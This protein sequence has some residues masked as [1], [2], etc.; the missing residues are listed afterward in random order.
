M[1]WLPNGFAF[2]HVKLNVGRLR[3]C[4][5]FA[6]RSIITFEILISLKHL[7]YRSPYWEHAPAWRVIKP[8]QIPEQPDINWP[9][10]VMCWELPK[11]VVLR[12]IGR[13]VGGVTNPYRKQTVCYR[14]LKRKKE[15]LLRWS[16][17]EAWDRRGCRTCESMD[18]CEHKFGWK[19]WIKET[20]SSLNIGGLIALKCIEKLISCC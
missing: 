2:R 1:A 6:L 20:P 19:V 5:V 15:K 11:G 4:I 10:V 12:Q 3:P 13:W 9:L 16:N 8:S 17:E 7:N 18:K 14:T